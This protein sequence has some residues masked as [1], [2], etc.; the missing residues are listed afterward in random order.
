MN[1]K[2]VLLEKPHYYNLHSYF[3][4]LI[5]EAWGRYGGAD[6]RIFNI[7]DP[8]FMEHYLDSVIDPKQTDLICS[9]ASI[10]IFV[11]KKYIFSD[12]GI[13]HLFI[14]ND[15]M[16]PYYEMASV[17]NMILAHVDRAES[18][19]ARSLGAK[20]VFFLPHAVDRNITIDS[21]RERPY[22]VLFCAGSYDHEVTRQ[23]YYR[24]FKKEEAQ[25]VDEAV[26][27]VYNDRIPSFMTFAKAIAERKM[28]LSWEKVILLNQYA[29]AYVRGRDRYEL[30]RSIKDAH[31]LV[32]GGIIW[33]T[34]D[35]SLRGWSELLSDMPNVTIRPTV[36]Y[37]EFLELLKLS[38]I[39]LNSAPHFT[40]GSSDRLLNSL[41]CGAFPITTENIWVR[42]NFVDGEELIIY[43]PK[44]KEGINDQVNALLSNEKLRREKA[45]KGRA[46]VMREH[47]WD[48]RIVQIDEELKRLLKP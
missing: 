24:Q 39:A 15:I 18:D 40:N 5:A 47:T 27:K 44:H 28:D 42:E 36:Y 6:I 19:I 31:V 13:P 48:Q 38:K 46:K 34:N 22:D 21:D 14:V 11:G 4:R 25:L 45:E 20:K 26:E 16:F 12:S 41:A 23:I 35:I 37:E 7:D 29:E 3:T 32:V 9:V 10:L 1:R 33:N 30:V 8:N 17:E 43:H 2:V